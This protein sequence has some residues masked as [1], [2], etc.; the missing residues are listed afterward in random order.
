MPL[1]HP[2]PLPPEQS[3]GDVTDRLTGNVLAPPH[4]VRW[5]WAL[6][7]AAILVAVFVVSVGWLFTF[8]VGV[9]GLNQEV[10]WG[11]AI[12]DYVWWIGIGNA[13]TF[14]SAMLLIANAGW[15]NS[16]N[17][18][19]E[20]M[21]LLAVLC[22]V[23][24]PVLHL[25]RPWLLY[26]MLPYPGTLGVQ[27]QFRSPLL[28]DVFA[29]LTY[30]SLSAMF[31][32]TGLIPDFASLR[33]RAAHRLPQ[34][35]YGVL[36]LG[37]RGS[38][39]HWALWRRAYLLTGALGMP[40]VVSV[41]SGVALL[42]AVGPQTGWHSTVFPPYFVLGALFSGFAVVIVIAAT[43]RAALGLQSLVTL[44]HFDLLGQMLLLTGLATFYAYLIEPFMAWY[45]GDAREMAVV[46]DR[47]VGHYAWVYWATLALNFLP[48]QSLWWRRMRRRLP[49]IVGCGVAVTIG[50]YGERYMLI[51]TTLARDF[52]RA[53]WR[54]YA[55]TVWDW[56]IYLG[57]IGVFLFLMLLCVRFLPMISLAEV[58]ETLRDEQAEAGHG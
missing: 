58:K 33:D 16:L 34:V 25:G 23:M 7:G 27:P 49:V 53:M 54:F 40:L 36:A 57:T 19:A 48:I 9:W 55:P 50:M 42:F 35:I 22:A 24:M 8:G 10:P 43:L 17:R 31:W 44:R 28:W 46:V 56:G 18:F 51:I 13:G 41:H 52:L 5:R 32:Y 39:R 2:L 45:S 20:T 14:I 29:N 30:L 3:F 21:T 38:A 11:L 1:V 4:L 37:W 15:R 47:A 26:F 6:G 12:V